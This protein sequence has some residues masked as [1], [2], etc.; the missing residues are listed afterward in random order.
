MRF[1]KQAVFFAFSAVF[2]STMWS[3]NSTAQECDIDN[4]SGFVDDPASFVSCLV[5]ELK[6]SNERI[7]EL[8]AKVLLLEGQAPV[9]GERGQQGPRGEQG[10]Q[11]LPGSDATLPSGMVAAFE[12]KCPMGWDLF[13]RA[14]GRFVVGAGHHANKDANGKQLTIYQ[15]H[16]LNGGEEEHRLAVEEMVSHVHAVPIPEHTHQFNW[17]TSQGAGSNTGDSLAGAPYYFPRTAPISIEAGGVTVN[18]GAQGGSKPHNNL[19]PFV[20]LYFCQKE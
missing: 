12:N 17:G 13:D 6:N 20:A 19:P 14:G 15:K 7:F 3:T 10:S 9:P 4:T 16:G 8:K 11:G 2:S 1:F 5:G 18:S